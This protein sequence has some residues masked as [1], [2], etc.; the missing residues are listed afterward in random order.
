MD[1]FCGAFYAILTTC[2][3]RM[4]EYTISD[5]QK[6][7]LRTFFFKMLLLT[8]SK[9]MARFWHDFLKPLL[10]NDSQITVRVLF[11]YLCR[12]EATRTPDPYVP[13]VVRYQLRYIPI[14]FFEPRLKGFFLAAGWLFIIS[15]H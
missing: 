7:D 4:Q 15:L 13:N 5:F 11:G 9:K 14:Y 2:N 1:V 6:P 12:D 10:Y 8:T 3:A